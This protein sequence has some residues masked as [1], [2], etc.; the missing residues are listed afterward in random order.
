MKKIKSIIHAMGLVLLI[1][2]ALCGIGL[3]GADPLLFKK[4]EQDKDNETKTER[5]EGQLEE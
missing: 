5:V 4:R 1:V 2:L 3:A